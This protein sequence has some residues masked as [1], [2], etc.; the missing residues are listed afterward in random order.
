MEL[1]LHPLTP[2][3][4]SPHLKG[5]EA[6]G[7]GGS[8]THL[9][10]PFRALLVALYQIFSEGFLNGK[11]NIGGG[12][13]IKLPLVSRNS[14]PQIGNGQ[15]DIRGGASPLRGLAPPKKKLYIRK[16]HNSKALSS[17]AISCGGLRFVSLGRYE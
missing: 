8:Y 3:T 14:L 10:C 12:G 16:W 15:R 2:Y 9:P 17:E 13:H 5:R 7:E 6:R 11:R 4:L 1:V